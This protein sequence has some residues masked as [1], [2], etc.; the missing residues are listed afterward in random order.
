M[1]KI[2]SLST[3]LSKK[4]QEELFEKPFEI[5]HH[6]IE[7]RT[8]ILQQPHL[9]ARTGLCFLYEISLNLSSLKILFLYT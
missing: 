9:K 8:W 3:Q 5:D 4:A 6:V 1:L 2:R 7:L